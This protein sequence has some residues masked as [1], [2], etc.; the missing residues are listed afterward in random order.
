MPLTDT[1]VR[2]AKTTEKPFKLADERGLYLLINT[3]GKYWRMDYRISGKRKTISMGIYPD[4]PLARAREPREE[5][6][7]LLAQGIDPSD[8]RKAVKSARIERAAN[9]LEVVA[10]EWFAKYS[11]GWVAHHADRTLRQLERD[12]FPYIGGRPIAEIAAPE[13]LAVVRRIESHGALE[14]A[15]RALA[16]CGQ[17]FRYAIATGRAERD[18]SADLRGALPP[19]KGK[20]FAAITDPQRVGGLLRAIDGYQGTLTV[21]CALRL[22]PLVFVRPGELRRAQWPHVDLEA[23]EWRYDVTKTGI[24]GQYGWNCKKQPA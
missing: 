20:H 8:N 18:L 17:V 19:V 16:N 15:H 24:P 4:V 5:A 9:S 1:A 2:N 3:T 13:L 12:A 11:S 14:T 10:R 7:K 21:R 22:V 23:A 6:R